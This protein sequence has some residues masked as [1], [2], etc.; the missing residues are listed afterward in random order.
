[1]HARV[2]LKTFQ[3]CGFELDCG[4]EQ[5]WRVTSSAPISRTGSHGF[6]QIMSRVDHNDERDVLLDDQPEH[7]CPICRVRFPNLAELCKHNVGECFEEGSASRAAPPMAACLGQPLPEPLPLDQDVALPDADEAD[8]GAPG[9]GEGH[10][11]PGLPELEDDQAARRDA[12]AAAAA[13]AAGP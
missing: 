2:P 4:C 1:M 11:G 12:P 9:P 6:C 8:A 3:D 7:L 5:V 10:A 13:A